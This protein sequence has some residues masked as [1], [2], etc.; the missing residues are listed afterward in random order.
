MG[1]SMH[2]DASARS[3][4][5]AAPS[6]PADDSARSRWATGT[7]PSTRLLDSD[8][9]FASR[10]EVGLHLD[11]QRARSVRCSSDLILYPIEPGNLGHICC[12]PYPANARLFR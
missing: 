6:T 3:T 1:C 5:A 10:P 2:M 4:Y 9:P 8:R 7:W 11:P 12:L